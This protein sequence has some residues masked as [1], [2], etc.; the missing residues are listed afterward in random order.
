MAL[1]SPIL[2]WQKFG[3]VAAAAAL[4]F[5]LRGGR[6]PVLV[7]AGHARSSSHGNAGRSHQ[8]L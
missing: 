5:F 2:S 1:L 8:I 7:P 6:M 4:R 3:A